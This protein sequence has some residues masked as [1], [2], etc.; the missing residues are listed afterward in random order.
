[1][2]HFERKGWPLRPNCYECS[3]KAKMAAAQRKRLGRQCAAESVEQRRS[4]GEDPQREART[5]ASV[6]TAKKKK[7]KK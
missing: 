4:L 3:S 6:N 7:K 1:M 2:A 5:A